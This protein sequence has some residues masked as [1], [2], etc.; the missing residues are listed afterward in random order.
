MLFSN[1]VFN[2]KRKKFFVSKNTFP[3]TIEVVKTRAAQLGIEVIVDDEYTYD[4]D[5]NGKEICGVL[6]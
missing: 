6:L 3:V 2:G 1:N 4:F 5:S